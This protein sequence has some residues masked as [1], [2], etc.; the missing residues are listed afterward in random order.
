[1]IYPNDNPWTN[2]D[3]G[4]FLFAF[5]PWIICPMVYYFAIEVLI[6]MEDHGYFSFE[7]G[8]AL[9]VL[10]GLGVVLSVVMTLV[11]T[12]L[13]PTGPAPVF[14]PMCFAWWLG[15]S[16]GCAIGGKLWLVG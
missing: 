4:G 2:A 13:A 15:V 6:V 14:N 7:N 11:S 8:R 1:M 3:L 16:L 9:W 10:M 5:G 12:Y